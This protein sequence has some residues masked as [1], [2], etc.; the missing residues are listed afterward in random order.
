MADQPDSVSVQHRW[1]RCGKIYL[2][3]SASLSGTIMVKLL[4]LRM[5]VL[6]MIVQYDLPVSLLY[7]LLPCINRACDT[8]EYILSKTDKY[9]YKDKDNDN[10]KYI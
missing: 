9:K 5:A 8:G 1:C 4:I 2:S 3:L 7:S 6:M 10:D